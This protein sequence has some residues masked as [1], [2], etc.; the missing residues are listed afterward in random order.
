[1]PVITGSTTTLTGAGNWP[2]PHPAELIGVAIDTTAVPTTRREWG[3]QILRYRDLGVYRCVDEAGPLESHAVWHDAVVDYVV[4][5]A[6]ASL[7]YDLA[8]GV[9]ISATEILSETPPTG[10]G[11][12]TPGVASVIQYD[13]SA[14]VSVPDITWTKVVPNLVD[15]HS[16]D[17]T[18]SPDGTGGVTIHTAGLY[19]ITAIVWVDTTGSLTAVELAVY[20]NGANFF[21]T[22]NN[23]LPDAPGYWINLSYMW[24]FS[25][26]D[27]IDIRVYQHS[28]TSQAVYPQYSV[29][30][31]GTA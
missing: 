14:S 5:K 1:M 11:G 16:D 3:S 17:A 9:T 31:L 25:A 10:G 13:N 24:V 28:G 29:A 26:A 23:F 20:C 2:W 4:G 6:P 19:L 27:N 18:L 7:D 12:G 22:S 15:V 8:D 30:F 21:Q